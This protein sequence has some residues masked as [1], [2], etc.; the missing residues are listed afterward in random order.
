MKVLCCLV[1]TFWSLICHVKCRGLGGLC[2]P[3]N[4]RGGGASLLS[5]PTDLEGVFWLCLCTLLLVRR[6]W[7]QWSSMNFIEQR[8]SRVILQQPLQM[9]SCILKA[10]LDPQFIFKCVVYANL[11]LFF[12]P[13]ASFVKFCNKGFAPIIILYNPDKLVGSL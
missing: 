3:S 2:L 13:T 1:N 10:F 4:R 12:V 5:V 7:W 11:L 6:R 8:L 9:Y